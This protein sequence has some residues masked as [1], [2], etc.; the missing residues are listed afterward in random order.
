MTVCEYMIYLCLIYCC[1]AIKRHHDLCISYK[2]ENLTGGF[3]TVL[4]S[5]SII[6]GDA[7]QYSTGIPA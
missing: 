6:M 3:I 2:R 5:Y 1:I 4:D 7:G